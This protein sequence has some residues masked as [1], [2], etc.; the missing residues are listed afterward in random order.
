MKKVIAF[1]STL[2]I[3][4][5]AKAQTTPTVV[6]KETVKPGTIQPVVIT[7]SA[8]KLAMKENSK[9][10]KI[11]HIKK[12]PATLPM[13]DNTIRMKENNATTKPHKD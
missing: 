1:F 9:P 6:K 12:T 13:K 7:D 11:D 2:L 5:G 4:A 10:I 8:K 3:F